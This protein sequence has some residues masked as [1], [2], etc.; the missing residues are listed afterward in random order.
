MAAGTVVTFVLLL[1]GFRPNANALEWLA[2]IGVLLFVTFAFTWLYVAAALKAKSL[3]T[4]SNLQ[5]PLLVLPFLGSGFAPT[6]SMPAGLRWFTEHQPFT[7]FTETVRGLFLGTEI[8]THALLTVAWCMAIA[9]FGYLA[10]RTR[11][12]R[13]PSR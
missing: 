5:L 11:Y 8:G 9:L 3:E 1:I 10:S 7:P 2:V 4:A 12:N 6:E 13:D